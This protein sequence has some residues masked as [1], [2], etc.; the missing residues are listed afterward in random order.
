MKKVLILSSIWG[1]ESIAKGVSD[2]LKTSDFETHLEIIRIDP[3]SETAYKTFYRFLPKLFKTTFKL[4]KYKLIGKITDKYFEASYFKFVQKLVRK[5]KPDIIISCYFAFNSSVEKL[6][7][8]YKFQY[9][10]IISD[11][12]TFTKIH[13]SK[14]G[15]NLVFDRKALTKMES[16]FHPRGLAQVGWFVESKFNT[17]LTRANARRYLGIDPHTFTLCVTGGSEG[18]Y[19][20]LK[21]I[22]SFVN[23][24][25]GVQIL[26]MCGR[27]R[28]LYDLSSSFAK[29][30]KKNKKIKIFPFKFT[31]RMN[32]YMS[33]SDLVIGKAGP[34]TIFESV[35]SGV[36]FFA[37]SHISG[38]E[39]GNLEIIKKYNI[40]YAEENPKKIA[41]ILKAVIKNPDVLKKFQKPIQALSKYN[42]DS[43]RKLLELLTSF[44]SS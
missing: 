42:Q 33:A 32:L 31:S 16:L 1:H 5:Y 35:A 27:N 28:Q 14:K 6:K 19:D 20:I 8:K 41:K 23:N 12:W 10:N 30:L 24:R 17:K 29:L 18:T 43:G 39:D 13:I 2:A 26:F 9:L 40:G 7:N 36:P 11:P 15:L 3:F 4:A 38:Q 37:V 22:N 34:N 21:I 25:R 44:S